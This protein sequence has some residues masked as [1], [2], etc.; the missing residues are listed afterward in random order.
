MAADTLSQSAPGRNL[1]LAAAKALIREGTIVRSR[2]GPLK[3]KARLRG[4]GAT[5][6]LKLYEKL[7]RLAFAHEDASDPAQAGF[8][9][10]EA[11][12]IEDRFDA[13]LALLKAGD[14]S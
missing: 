8:S 3:T 10:A 14:G 13:I 7:F 9:P 1:P 5:A 4:I 2:Y 6:R 12:R 11:R